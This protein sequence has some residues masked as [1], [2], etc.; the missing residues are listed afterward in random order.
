[1]NDVKSALEA[2]VNELV[3][4]WA[5]DNIATVQQEFFESTAWICG[6]GLPGAAKGSDDARGLLAELLKQAPLIAIDIVDLQSL[7]ASSALT[8]L[9]WHILGA[10]K[11]ILATM[12]SLTVWNHS[13]GSWKISADMF[14]SGTC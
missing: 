14:T 5:P 7:G 2:R 10:E 4:A 8:W 3:A 1:M 6:E 9:H 11:E 12:R 13:E